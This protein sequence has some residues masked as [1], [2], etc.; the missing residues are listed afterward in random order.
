MKIKQLIQTYA[1]PLNDRYQQQLLPGQRR[2]MDAMLA[3]RSHCGEF[4]SHCDEC[5]NRYITPLSCGHRSCP[6]CQHHLGEAWLQRQQLKLLPVTYFMVTFTLPFELRDTAY[7]HQSIMYDLLFRAGIE[8]L[9]TIGK[10]NFKLSLGLT[11]VLH[12]HKRDKGYHPHIHVVLPGGGIKID[13]P[14]KAWQALPQDFIVNEFAL[15]RIFR[16][17]FLRMVFEQSISIPSGIPKQWVSNIRNVGRGKKALQY[18]SRYLYR[19][20]ISENDIL[21][22]HQGQVTFRYRDSQSK[23]MTTTTKFAV[24]FIWGLLKHVLPR[25]FR[26]VRDYGFLHGNAKKTLKRIQLMLHVKLPTNPAVKSPMICPTCQQEMVIDLVI[27]KSIPRL[28]TFYKTMN[29]KIPVPQVP[30]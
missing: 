17:I 25:G 4:Y 26:R 19:G 22:D 2:A 3:C 9:Q 14:G 18:L 16:G 30:S 27:P 6:Q 7:R 13:E 8:A 21:S 28:F 29:I 11:G 12:T 23:K 1:S 5:S 15:A 10:N 24:D 20:V